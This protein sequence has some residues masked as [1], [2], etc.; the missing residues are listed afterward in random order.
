LDEL[1]KGTE[2]DLIH[3]DTLDLMQYVT[4]FRGRPV[5]LNHHNIESQVAARRAAAES[6]PI[7]RHILHRDAKKIGILER[8]AAS[9]VSINLVVSELDAERLRAVAPTAR[10]R[11]VENGV[12]PEYFLPTPVPPP[13]AKSVIF[14]GGMNWHPNRDAA[15]WFVQAIWPALLADD[16]GRSA[17]LVGRFP[18]EAVQSAARDARLRAPGYVPDVRPYLQ[19]SAVYIC[20]MRIGGG[21][22]LKIL[23]ALAM[24]KPIVATSVSVEGLDLHEEVHFLGAETPEDFVRQ[25]RRLEREPELVRRLTQAGR[26]L[27]EERYSW[28][29]IGEHLD[30]AYRDALPPRT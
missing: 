9:I 16:P 4:P 14:V 30:L 7:A 6:G 20:P 11:V 18:P 27:V 24:K 28:K 29:R 26:Q 15:T 2:F 8:S 5:V 19:E 25:V 17:L 12:D 23:D 3:L 22:R 10:T 13:R 21:T 1:A